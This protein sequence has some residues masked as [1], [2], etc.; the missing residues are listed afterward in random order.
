MTDS[1]L[2]VLLKILMAVG[3]T[4][5]LLGVFLHFNPAMEALGVTG[6]VISASLVAV[7]MAMSLPTKM[8]LTFLF[9]RMEAEQTEQKIVQTAAKGESP[10]ND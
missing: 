9:M 1:K 5:I 3:I 4:L 10:S 2:I 6:I 7:G 8:Y